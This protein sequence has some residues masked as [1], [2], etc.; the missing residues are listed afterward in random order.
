MLSSS[1]LTKFNVDLH[2]YFEK[3]NHNMKNVQYILYVW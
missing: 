3:E 2:I 1:I